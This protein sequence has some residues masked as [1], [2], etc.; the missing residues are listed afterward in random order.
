MRPRAL[1]TATAACIASRGD[2]HMVNVDFIDGDFDVHGRHITA[3]HVQ[4]IYLLEPL[5][6][7]V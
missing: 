5:G 1:A 7:T 2:V 3:Q 6:R 4:T